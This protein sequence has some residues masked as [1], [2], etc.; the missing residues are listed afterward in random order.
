MASRT[1]GMVGKIVYHFTENLQR[2]DLTDGGMISA[3][4]LVNCVY[5]RRKVSKSQQMTCKFRSDIRDR[6]LIVRPIVSWAR[7][8]V[9]N[10]EIVD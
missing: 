8:E 1:T 6:L 9:K 5:V 4:Q 10:L 3:V 7:Y 2:R